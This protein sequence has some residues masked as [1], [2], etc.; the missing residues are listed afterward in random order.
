MFRIKSLKKMT[1]PEIILSLEFLVLDDPEG[2]DF[3]RP[4]SITG[5]IRI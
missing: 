4:Y 3:V 2:S 5:R 1:E